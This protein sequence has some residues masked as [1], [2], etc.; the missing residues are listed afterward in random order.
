MIA[1]LKD[2][3]NHKENMYHSMHENIANLATYLQNYVNGEAFL[4]GK[5]GCNP[6]IRFIVEISPR[7][8]NIM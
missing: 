6:S 7:L 4:H 3:T 1:T 8:T 2:L 5:T